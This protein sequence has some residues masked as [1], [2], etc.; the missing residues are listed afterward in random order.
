VSASFHVHV[1]G[2]GII[3]FTLTQFTVEADNLSSRLIL[4]LLNV[5]MT[6]TYTTMTH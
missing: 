4:D 2:I 3:E 1:L 5:L 6:C